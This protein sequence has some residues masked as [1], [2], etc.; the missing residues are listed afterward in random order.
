MLEVSAIPMASPH[1]EKG[2]RVTPHLHL[3]CFALAPLLFP[4]DCIAQDRQSMSF[5]S[6]VYRK[7][8]L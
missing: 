4:G 6:H 8:E 1:S 7:Y 5:L 2:E 3:T